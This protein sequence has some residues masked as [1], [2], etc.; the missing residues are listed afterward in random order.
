MATAVRQAGGLSVERLSKAFGTQRALQDVDL[1]VLSGEVHAVVG[2][3]GSGKSTL[4]KTL[5]GFHQ[6][7]D[8][9]V[10]AMDGLAF[11]VGSAAAA[12]KAGLRFV[13]QDLGLLDDLDAVDNVYLGGRFPL[14]G[15]RGIGWA[16]ARC[17]ARAQLGELGF[18]L[19]VRVPVR[20]L[21]PAQRT[22][23]AVAR[24]LRPGGQPGRVMVLDEPT[25][26]LPAREVQTLFTVVRQLQRQG[27]GV[28][29]ISHHLEEVFALADRVTVLRDGVRVCTISTRALQEAELVELMVG[30]Q[31]ASDVRTTRQRRGTTPSLVVRHLGATHLRD[32]ALAVHPG[33]V[34][35]VTGVD[36]S[37]REELASAVFGGVRRTGIVEVDGQ[38]I[39]DLR[40]DI[41]VRRRVGLVPADRSS[42]GALRRLSVTDNLTVSSLRTKMAGLAVDHRATRT[43]TASWISRLGIRTSSPEAPIEALSGG[44][45]QKVMLARW[46]RTEPRVLLLDEPTQGVDVEAVAALWRLVA[47]AAAAGAAVLAC[48]CDTNELAAHC[49]RVLVLRHGRVVADVPAGDLDPSRLDALAISD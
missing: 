10:A 19:D 44:N 22:A 32:L 45:Q 7:S 39:P 29:Y 14:N 16:R 13:H 1:Q 48:S 8:G 38:P 43:E 15:A 21:S 35:G 27:L 37:G 4:V 20:R 26:A 31:P 34:V 25:A 28:L 18:D 40:P 17:E 47:E 30:K 2:H 33:E 49:D 9:A 6:P 46:L 24:A 12:D 23:V 11:E 42:E 36:G 5:A 41:A 3:N